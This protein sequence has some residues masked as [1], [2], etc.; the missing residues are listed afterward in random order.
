MKKYDWLFL[1]LDNTILDFD[2]SSKAAFFNIFESFTVEDY[3]LYRAYNHAVWVDFEKGKISKEELKLKRW[4]DFFDGKKIDHDAKSTNEKY[5]DHIK[6]N[7]VFVEGAEALVKELIKEYS[8]CI[9]TNGLSEVQ[10]S[11][12]KLSGIA[13]L[14]EHVVISDTIGVAKPKSEFFDYTFKLIGNPMRED[15]LIIGDTLTSDIRGG[16]DYDVDTCWFNYF[17]KD[18]ETTYRPTYEVKD[19][20]ELRRLLLRNS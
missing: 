17:K 7:P 12:L 13:D 19:T 20:S 11:R 4:N 9:I 14:I 3:K 8:L 6:M 1:D 16:L 18:N 2:A 5:F 15:A 10:N